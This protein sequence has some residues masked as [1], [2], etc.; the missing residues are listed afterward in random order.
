MM[1]N[2]DEYAFKDEPPAVQKQASAPAAGTML[3]CPNCGNTLS[4]SAKL[5][6][7]CGYNLST[8]EKLGTQVA[9][10]PKGAGGTALARAKAG[11]AGGGKL[12]PG[13]LKAGASSLFFGVCAIVLGVLDY[14]E[15]I[16][17]RRRRWAGIFNLISEEWGI[18]IGFS[19]F[20]VFLIG[21]GVLILMGKMSWESDKE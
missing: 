19:I 14:S 11:A 4:P 16:T 21:C 17:M 9:R 7:N 15:V 5:C 20:G 8:G 1:D 18:L 6:V 12:A 10:T 13:Q 2:P 3:A